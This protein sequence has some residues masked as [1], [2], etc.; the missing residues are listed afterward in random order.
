MEPPSTAS[1]AS[2]ASEPVAAAEPEHSGSRSIVPPDWA[3]IAAA[4]LAV[5]TVVRLGVAADSFAWA[6]V[7]V[8]LVGVTAYDL[9]NR[10]IKN[11]VTVPVSVAAVLMRV[12]FERSALVEVIVAG[13]V[14]FLAFFALALIL[15]GGLGMGDV[16][17]AGMLGFLLGEKVLPALFIGAI[18]GGVA[19]VI[20]L[21]GAAGRRATMAYGPYLAVGGMLA[22]LISQPPRLI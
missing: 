9:N 14:A 19:A 1:E 13:F 10:L 3:V 12:A 4:I 7:Q 17:L 2:E 21:R 8:I 18:A 11:A 16:K 22:I 5:A 20:I 15:R 6:V